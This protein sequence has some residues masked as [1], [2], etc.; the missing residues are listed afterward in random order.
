MANPN[1]P[2]TPPPSLKQCC[3]KKK[4]TISVCEEIVTPN[5]RSSSLG[6]EGDFLFF[7]QK[8]VDK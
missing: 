8:E 7:F 6:R 3:S 5:A 2:P 4:N 1:P